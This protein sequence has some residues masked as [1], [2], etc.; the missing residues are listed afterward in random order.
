[1]PVSQVAAMGQIKSQDC[2][3]RLDDRHVSGCIGL[4]TGMGLH[5]CVF[6]AEELLGAVAR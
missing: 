2:V 5:V 6:G 4:G 3:A 1:M